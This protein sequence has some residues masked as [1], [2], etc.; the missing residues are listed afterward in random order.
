[1]PSRC[2]FE[3]MW[4]GG[5]EVDTFIVA[6]ERR[7][8]YRVKVDW[9]GIV[10]TSRGLVEAIAADISPA[11]VYLRCDQ[12]LQSSEP[13]RLT[14]QP[15]EREPL[16]ITGAVARSNRLTESTRPH[17]LGLHFTAVPPEDRRFLELFTAQRLRARILS[18]L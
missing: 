3:T 15:P 8:C 2:G 11:G 12:P 6:E 1:M 5:S 4:R 7:R 16:T 10:E 17:V 14:I 18:T 9:P 13:I